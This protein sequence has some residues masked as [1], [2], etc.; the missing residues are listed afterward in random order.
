[1]VLA[2]YSREKQAGIGL[3]HCVDLDC[4][5]AVVHGLRAHEPHGRAVFCPRN[6]Q[7]QKAVRALRD[8]RYSKKC[9]S[10]IFE[11]S[12]GAARRERSCA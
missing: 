1:M 11:A 5:R 6:G 3:K 12:S 7:S 8:K 4:A 9:P 2:R 10:Y